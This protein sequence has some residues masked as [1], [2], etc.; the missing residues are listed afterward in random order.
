M[1]KYRYILHRDNVFKNCFASFF[2]FYLRSGK[3]ERDRDRFIYWFTLQSLHLMELSPVKA[4][5]LKF[6]QG[7]PCVQQGSKHLS[8]HL[9]LLEVYICRKLGSEV[10]REFKPVIWMA[11]GI[12]NQKIT[13]RLLLILFI[14]D[15]LT[16][17]IFFITIIFIGVF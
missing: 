1:G 13:P 6:G 2:S 17:T 11:V 12:L 3:T 15:I 8:H 5:S 4:G 16:T 10:E 14:V 9:L 7:L